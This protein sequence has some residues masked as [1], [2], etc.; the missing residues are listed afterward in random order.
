MRNYS[1]LPTYADHSIIRRLILPF[2]VTACFF[3]NATKANDQKYSID[4]YKIPFHSTSWL[5]KEYIRHKNSW[6][7][8]TLS[9]FKFIKSLHINR[10]DSELS[11]HISISV[12]DQSKHL[13]L[14]TID[15]PV[16]KRVILQ[17]GVRNK[18]ARHGSNS[19]LLQEKH[20]QT[21]SFNIN[22]TRCDDSLFQVISTSTNGAWTCFNTA[23]APLLVINTLANIK[24]DV[25]RGDLQH[26]KKTTNSDFSDNILGIDPSSFLFAVIIQSKKKV[27]EKKE[28]SL[29]QAVIGFQL[30]CPNHKTNLFLQIKSNSQP[31]EDQSPFQHACNENEIELN[32][33]ILDTTDDEE[34]KAFLKHAEKQAAKEPVE[35]KQF[36]PNVTVKPDNSH[37]FQDEG[38]QLPPTHAQQ[39]ITC[40]IYENKAQQLKAVEERAAE[41]KHIEAQTSDVRQIFLDLH[42]MVQDQGDTVDSIFDHVEQAR[43]HGEAGNKELVKAKKS[44]SKC[45]KRK[46]Y[47]GTTAATII[48]IAIIILAL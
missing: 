34:L 39:T 45:R 33:F 12:D 23:S 11:S 17:K 7:V 46:I 37:I 21:P 19:G 9:K 48:T 20:I 4:V 15:D 8:D 27:S 22:I 6:G 43:G 29:E 38:Y 28:P 2:L 41:I 1:A 42:N 3:I 14:P 47:L 26:L 30:V 18:L 25:E 40:Q 44:A 10:R 36:A 16:I 13:Q 24:N 35:S 32:P 31:P 5:L